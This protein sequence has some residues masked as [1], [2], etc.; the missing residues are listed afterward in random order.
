MYL[1]IC[2]YTYSYIYIYIYNIHEYTYIYIYIYISLHDLH[3]SHHSLNSPE[4]HGSCFRDRDVG[5]DRI[6]D[7]IIKTSLD[8]HTSDRSPD[9]RV[10]ASALPTTAT[11]IRSN[12]SDERYSPRS[13]LGE[14]L[15]GISTR[16]GGFLDGIVIEGSCSKQVHKISLGRAKGSIWSR[17][18]FRTAR[19]SR[20]PSTASHSIVRVVGRDLSWGRRRLGF[21]MLRTSRVRSS[22]TSGSFS[23][24]PKEHVVITARIGPQQ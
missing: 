5:H 21:R 11:S 17:L 16:G 9:H 2:I 13:K 19:T 3:H 4:S 14:I 23:S 15:Y 20:I 22:K 8:L 6:E 1:C 24:L 7:R 18:R 10:C 12:T